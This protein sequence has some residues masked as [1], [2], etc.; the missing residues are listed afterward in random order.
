M[1]RFESLRVRVSQPSAVVFEGLAKNIVAES[2]FGSFCVKPN[3]VDLT[4]SLKAGIILVRMEDGEQFIGC[5]R[6]LMVKCGD[7][8]DITTPFALSGSDLLQLGT[9][10]EAYFSR[11]E[12][13]E[14]AADMAML[15]LESELIRQFKELTD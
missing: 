5:D 12:N 3:H 11:L 10:L 13:E 4:T 9:E 8:I 14:K 15:K 1:K 2:V 6:A 7:R